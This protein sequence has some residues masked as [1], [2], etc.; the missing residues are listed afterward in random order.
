[1]ASKDIFNGATAALA[2]FYAYVNTVA[3][4]IGMER[5]IGL[6][7]KTFENRGAMRGKRIKE[8]ANIKE[9]DAKTAW[10]LM[11]AGAEGIGLSHKVVEESP[12]RVVLRCGRCSFYET[13][14]MQGMDPKTIETIC[15]ASGVKSLSTLVKQLNPALSY[16]VRKFRSAADDFC[17]E[18]IILG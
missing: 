5:A 14:Q 1:M 15:H 16:R 9:F 6:M 13:A 10:S 12:Q 8:Q 11:R 18:E 2:L 3:Q 17:E 4:D 7:N